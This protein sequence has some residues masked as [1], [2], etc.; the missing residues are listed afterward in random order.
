MT[1]KEKQFKAIKIGN[2]P[3]FYRT[4]SK[5]IAV[6]PNWNVDRSTFVN[7]WLMAGELIKNYLPAPENT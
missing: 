7:L 3:V 2:R 4:E 6:A 5:E 1:E